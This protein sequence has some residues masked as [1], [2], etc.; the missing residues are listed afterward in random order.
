[1]DAEVEV[2]S[3]R[4]S[5][6]AFAA[7]SVAVVATLFEPLF[8]DQVV[9]GV[10]TRV[11]P[12]FSHHAQDAKAL[13]PRAMNFM[14][15]DLSAWLLPERL[16]QL[17]AFAE[18]RVPLWNAGEG[19]GQPLLAT[20]GDA[21][22][23]PA[24]VLDLV[25]PPARAIAVSL[26]LHLCLLGFGTWLVMRRAG[27]HPA[28]ALFGAVVMAL[29]GYATCHFQAPLILRAIAWLPW[30]HLALARLV[31]RPSPVRIGVLGL[32][33]GMSFL[34]GF[35]QASCLSLYAALLITMP[36]DRRA[37][38]GAAVAVLLGAAI[39][40]V[41]LVPATELVG[42]S[43]RAGGWSVDTLR[44]KSLAPQSLVGFVLP[45]FFGSPVAD[46]SVA[47]PDLPSPWE[48]PSY[49]AWQTQEVQNS[50]EEN[51]LFA[52]LIPLALAA[53]GCLRRRARLA[54]L[55]LGAV[56]LVAM[57]PPV[58]AT[59][60]G[61][62]PG[63][64]Y[65]SPKRVLFL[66]AYAVAWLSAL[67]VDR[68]AHATRPAE[69]KLARGIIGA[70]AILVFIGVAAAGPFERWLFPGASAADQTWFRAV[71]ARD[72]WMALAA[73]IGLVI[74]GIAVHLGRVRL[75][76]GLL[77][78]G[79]TL[80]LVAFARH[81]NPAQD[82]LPIYLETPAI[83]WLR[84]HGAT[85][86]GRILNFGDQT[87]LV[88]SVAQEFGLRSCNSMASLLPRRSGELLRAIEPDCLKLDN[89]CFLGPLVRPGSL[90]SPILDLI[91]ARF[92]VAGVSGYQSLGEGIP[93]LGVK[94]VYGNEAERLAI[95]ERPS[96]LPPAFL[97]E[98]LVVVRDADARLEAMSAASFEPERVALLDD[99]LDHMGLGLVDGT[100]MYKRISPEVIEVEVQAD[101]DAFL[102]VTETHL[103]GWRCE[104]D[105]SAAAIVR[106]D[107]AFMGVPL[108]AGARR[109][110]LVYDPRSFT[111]G[112]ILSVLG[113]AACL[114]LIATA[115]F[116][117]AS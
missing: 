55:G 8:L 86:D 69:G 56:L 94:L 52:G 31:E 79:T 93:E 33:V 42:E 16:A 62:L 26:A 35:P 18:G 6:I 58:L 70:G 5:L 25:L 14:S 73:G 10:D 12:P 104:V 74:A 72:L 63:M 38:A 47:V 50:F 65:G 46:I 22:F 44:A 96:A 84:E 107:H 102:I 24:R 41:H 32:V 45:H 17:R 60:T 4:Q 67:E 39:A 110:R 91:G 115:R 30:M 106:A 83:S 108:H 68:L 77:L 54:T 23:Y 111:A 49:L 100:A 28:A 85:T 81:T 88:G 95:Y 2:T 29:S 87:V 13:A 37:L 103:P 80:E 7:L 90:G 53:A 40:A 15:L 116:S 61:L 78:V 101:G 48:F 51:V 114:G 64:S 113:L 82:A 98:E 99:D 20:L 11:F 66:A 112:W 3:R 76:L 89:P 19:M 43:W 97:V 117:R 9:L 57:A 71:V 75:A 36:K 27:L 21:P 92:V 34:V 109:V 1:M 59:L 105:G